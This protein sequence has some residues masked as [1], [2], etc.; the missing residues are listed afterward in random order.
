MFVVEGGAEGVVL[1]EINKSKPNFK[2]KSGPL[3]CRA[4]SR[5]PVAVVGFAGQRNE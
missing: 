1:C 2:S 4:V 3:L 5:N